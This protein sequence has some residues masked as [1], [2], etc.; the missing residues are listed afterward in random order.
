M[1]KKSKV[2]GRLA[3]T[4]NRLRSSSSS[5]SSNRLQS[6]VNNAKTRLT[7]SGA[8][9][10]TRDW[11]E[12]LFNLPDD[13]NILFD[14]FEI[15]GRPQ[16]A[17]FGAIDAAQTGGDVGKGALE[18]L[19]GNKTTSG[20]QLLRNAGMSDQGIIGDVGLDD[21]LGFGLDVFAD[22]VDLALIPVTGGASA[23]V[24]A[25]INAA[26][27]ATDAARVASKAAKAANAVDTASD[28]ARSI[29]FISPSDAI[30][31]AAGRAVKGGAGIADNLIQKGLGAVDTARNSRLDKAIQ[32]AGSVASNVQRSNLLTDYN[33]IKRSL[34]G[35]FDASKALPNNMVNRARESTYA[36]DFART[37]SNQVLDNLVNKTRSYADNIAQS[38]NRNVDDVMKEVSE[39]ITRVIESEMDTAIDGERW[40]RNISSKN[41]RNILS[42]TDESINQVKNVLDQYPSIKYTIREGDRGTELVI[43]TKKSKLLNDFK[44]N[45]NVQEAFRN[46]NLNRSLNYTD[47]QLKRIND[48]KQNSEFMSL[49]DDTKQAYQDISRIIKEETGAD[50]SEIINRPGYVRRAQGDLGEEARNIASGRGNVINPKSFESRTRIDP[51]EVENVRAQEAI[52]EAVAK[53]KRTVDNLTKNLSANK[54]TILE[55]QISDVSRQITETEAK[56][57]AKLAKLSAN[58]AKKL[59]SLTKT[60]TARQ[61]LRDAL[62]DKIIDKASKIQDPRLSNKFL[63]DTT[64]LAD[65][66]KQF[67]DLIKQIENSDNLKPRQVD[68]LLNRASKLEQRI[69]KL[70]N[71][72]RV[73]SAKISGTIDDAALKTIDDT[74]K[75][76][77]KSDNLTE[78][79]VKQSAA[80]AKLRESE[81]LIR[82]TFSDKISRLKQKQRDFELQIGA[83]D[84]SADAAKLK[85][86]ENLQ[87]ATDVLESQQ[88]KE[89]FNLDAMAGIEDFINNATATSRGAKLYN[90]ALLT[91]T[92]YDTDLVK[93]ADDLVDG[94][95]PY[96]F[97]RVDASK[98]AK[99]VD[100]IKGILPENSTA[101]QDFVNSLD[102][103]VVYMDKNLANL[104]KVG[105]NDGR[106]MSPILKMVNSFNNTFKKFK[107]LTPGFQIRNITG[108]AVNLA[109]SGVP[110]SQIPGLYQDASKLLNNMDNIIAKANNGLETLTKAELDDYNLIRQ[111]YQGGFNNAGT[112]LQDLEE[113]LQGAGNSKGVISRLV[114]MNGDLNG[115]IDSLNRMALLKYANEHPKFVSNLGFN[116]PIEAVRFALMD[117]NN[118]SDFERNVVKKIIPFYTFT[119]QNLLFQASNL[120]KNANKYNKLIKG[121]NSIYSDLDED[122]YYQY[123]K[124]NFQLPLPWSDDEGNRIYLKLNLPVSDLGEFA[125]EPLRRV[126]S[127]TSPLIRTPFEQVTGVDTFTGNELNRSTIE[128]LANT[129]GIDTI[130]TNVFDKAKAIYDRF[131]GDISNSEMWAEILNSIAQNTNAERVANSRVYQELE[132]YQ[133]MI[134]ELKSQGIDVP[135]ISELNNNSRLRLN[136]LANTRKR[137]RNSN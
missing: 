49:V 81:P 137:A 84:E 5:S 71:D 41:K 45:P 39:D 94:Q 105:F 56:R 75:A 111:F 28:A 93:A 3:S 64:K 7:D 88:G 108:N 65:S 47:E 136:S 21:I 120:T 82:E 33:N 123:Q 128:T 69:I 76:M 22:P 26:D 17:L 34:T 9:T 79:Y 114:Q 110:T 8:D 48:L 44:N 77:D 1:A 107:V 112:T 19:T 27:T 32:Q 127:S 12:K 16:Q 74:V 59:E 43:N 83:L 118:M 106:Q 101:L 95:I 11:F 119:K 103:K 70:E 113:V 109:L 122:E 54:R 129:L 62:S 53:N 24:S 68:S 121:Y 63:N 99:Q 40:L 78:R 116:S 89:L 36:A 117:P 126:V 10:D 124:E 61:T 67:N 55:E 13:Q 115:A 25:G 85:R 57:D 135:T 102:G 86:I 6:Q 60:D 42:A 72:V 18:G 23:A 91:G 125:E 131:N 38:T 80:Y 92:L 100:A 29:R 20:G 96:N 58:Q 14:I 30:F 15:L 132:K 52:T 31:R 73:S 87:K 50:F 4:T 37:R 66:K 51:G 130:T 133:E 97:T 90:E 2:T 46:L 98:I 134:S 104:F 35:V